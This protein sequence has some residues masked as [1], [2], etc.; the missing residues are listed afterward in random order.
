M[1]VLA[2]IRTEVEAMVLAEASA[3]VE[4]V[5]QEIIMAEPVT[6]AM[7]TPEPVILV[8]ELRRA[9]GLHLA[10]EIQRARGLHPARELRKDLEAPA[11]RAIPGPVQMEAL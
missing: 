2:E 11:A 3:R 5:I 1:E 10:R 9:R 6:L 7:A 4:M 8:A